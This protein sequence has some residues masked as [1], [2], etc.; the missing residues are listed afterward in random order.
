M[1]DLCHDHNF[2]WDIELMS[3][4]RINEALARLVRNKPCV[5]NFFHYLSVQ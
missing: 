1:M 2:T 4:D 5:V 3:R